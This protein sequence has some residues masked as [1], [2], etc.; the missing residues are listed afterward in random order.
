MILVQPA[1]SDDVEKEKKSEREESPQE[2]K[3]EEGSKK[4]DGVKIVLTVPSVPADEDGSM[5][6]IE[7][8][9]G[10]EEAKPVE[11][12][13]N[14]VESQRVGDGDDQP[15]GGTESD[16]KIEGTKQEVKD[17]QTVIDAEDVPTPV[18]SPIPI[19]ESKSDKEVVKEKDAETVDSKEEDKPTQIDKQDEQLRPESS[20]QNTELESSQNASSL[21]NS[22]QQHETDPTAKSSHPLKPLPNIEEGITATKSEPRLPLLPPIGSKKVASLQSNDGALKS[23]S[24]SGIGY[25][26]A[27]RD[28]TKERRKER[29]QTAAR[30]TS[31]LAMTAKKKR[32]L[33][34]LRSTSGSSISKSK[35][36][37]SS[38]S[39][40]SLGQKSKSRESLKAGA[41]SRNSAINS[42]SSDNLVNGAAKKLSISRE[43]LK[44][45]SHVYSSAPPAKSNES[46]KRGD[47]S[48]SNSSKSKEKKS[49]EPQ[50]PQEKVEVAST[51]SSDTKEDA[52]SQ[53]QNKD[54]DRPDT[55]TKE[56]S[57]SQSSS[58]QEQS[59]ASEKEH[60]KETTSAPTQSTHVEEKSPSNQTIL[61][62]P[63]G[64]E[65]SQVDGAGQEDNAGQKEIKI[66]DQNAQE[67]KMASN[68]ASDSVAGGDP[69]LDKTEKKQT[70]PPSEPIDDPSTESK[71]SNK[72]E[73]SA[74]SEIE[75][76]TIP[77]TS[78]SQ[79]SQ[80]QGEKKNLQN[81]ATANP[82]SRELKGVSVV[83]ND[84][85]T[86]R[87][88]SVDITNKVEID[89]KTGQSEQSIVEA[90]E[91]SANS[92]PITTNERSTVTTPA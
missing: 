37:S 56:P 82:Q 41:P 18:T 6:I 72:E 59:V 21:E 16:A 87:S 12:P 91:K 2:L 44:A 92:P 75:A 17:E 52:G 55:E 14:E 84:D 63:K 40:V 64:E 38:S 36:S 85:T 78:N 35:K 60:E 53:M 39:S 33:D 48:R 89:K 8:D 1:K 15:D 70:P 24:A 42:R 19:P 43:S 49:S 77:Q 74:L 34:T 86:S 73:T 9:E 27:V 88:S 29:E 58:V 3:Q 61:E 20:N 32:S 62:S 66:S 46:H 65:K 71:Q 31:E 79:Q 13:P 83:A 90:V 47:S 25:D 68:E 4:D 67:E 5:E 11:G 54:E 51:V 50:K 10:D 23:H 57:T 30:P 26:T 80:D 45:A 69:Q 81:I 28:A 7:L 76:E 22:K